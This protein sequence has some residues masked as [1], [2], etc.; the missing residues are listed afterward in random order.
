MCRAADGGDSVRGQ[1][2]IYRGP[3][4]PPVF[5]LKCEPDPHGRRELPGRKLASGVGAF[6][7]I[8]KYFLSIYYVPGTELSP[9][10]YQGTIQT[11]I[12]ALMEPT[13]FW[14]DRQWS[15]HVH[16]RW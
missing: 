13:V 12:P 1:G 6:N 5:S 4:R 9:R 7:P 15:K 14:E 16:F 8:H 3:H 10:V 2:P 11:K